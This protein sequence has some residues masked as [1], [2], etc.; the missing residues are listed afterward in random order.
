M[1]GKRQRLAAEIARALDHWFQVPF[2]WGRGDCF[3]SLA[4]II[5]SARGYDPASMFRGRYTTA[6]GAARATR[7]HGGFE[8]AFAYVAECAEWKEID[9]RRAAVGDVGVLRG[10]KGP[11]CGVMKN[12]DGLWIGRTM[13]AFAAVPTDKVARAWR[14]S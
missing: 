12:V 3:L 10:A 9:P 11:R 1:R 2:A 5:Q 14:V 4:D 7:V 6:I 13:T 8:G